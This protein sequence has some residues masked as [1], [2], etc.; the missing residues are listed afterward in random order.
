MSLG[1][2][3]ERVEIL[4]RLLVGR[5]KVIVRADYDEAITDDPDQEIGCAVIITHVPQAGQYRLESF[6]ILRGD[7]F[8]YSDSTAYVCLMRLE[9]DGQVQR[10]EEIVLKKSPGRGLKLLDHVVTYDANDLQLAA[11]SGRAQDLVGATFAQLQRA[12]AMPLNSPARVE[13]E[14]LIQS[15]LGQRSRPR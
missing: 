10:V 12:Y 3:F 7:R 5:S 2:D 15:S 4:H 8:I 14:G 11:D 6:S 1:L 13:M 9:G